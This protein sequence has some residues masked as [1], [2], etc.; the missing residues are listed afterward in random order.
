VET[1]QAAAAFWGGQS[2]ASRMSCCTPAGS[3]RKALALEEIKSPFDD[4][5]Q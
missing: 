5:R 3:S 1:E 4:L 2:D